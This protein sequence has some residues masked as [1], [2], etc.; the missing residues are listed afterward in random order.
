M[1][2]REIAQNLQNASWIRKMFEEGDRLRREFGP[3]NVF[4]FSLGNPQEEPPAVVREAFAQLAA[5]PPAGMHRYMSNAGF[6]E[7]RE[8]V[9]AEISRETGTDFPSD[10]VLMTNGAAGGLNVTLRALLDPGDEVIILS[11]YF[12]E[13]LFYVRNSQGIPVVC[14]TGSEDFL[15]CPEELEKALS[16]RTKALIINSPN[17]PT[18]VVYPEEIL[19]RMAAVI[20]E[21]EE[22]IGRPVFVI[23]DEPYKKIVYDSAGVPE[24]FNI[25]DNSVVVNSYSKSLGLAGERIGYAAVNPSAEG[26]G[27]LMEAL[28]FCQRTLGFVNAPAIPQRLVTDG[29]AAQVD[30][31]GYQSKRDLLYAALV[32]SGFSCVKPG[33]AFYLF[34]KTPGDEM[35]FIRSAQEFNLLFVPG[36]GFGCPGHFRISYCM[37]EEM[38][39]RAIPVIKKLASRL[40]P[41]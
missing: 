18:G 24:T 3:E 21:A 7:T 4:D 28:V 20:K 32:N 23:S 37:D 38:I 31:S 14:P 34:P 9:A 25:F 41:G 11:P 22:K 27:E 35:E 33:G 5:H 39:Q 6:P 26:A 8:A 40:F 29:A 36:R 15:P 12:V 13:Y 16:E 17:N 10:L 19:Q 1:I 2:S 30:V